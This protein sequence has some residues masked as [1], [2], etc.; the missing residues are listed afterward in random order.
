MSFFETVFKIIEKK[1][2]SNVKEEKLSDSEYLKKNNELPF[3]WI[4]RNREFTNKINCEF[5]HFLNMWL[6]ARKKSPKELYSALKSFVLYLEDAEKLCKSK[7]ECFEFWFNRILISPG[8][9][10]QRKA[11]LQHLTTNFDKLQHN[12]E[13]RASLLTTFDDEIIKKLQANDGILQADF[14]KMFDECVQSDVSS[15][16]YFMAKSGELERTKSG[17]SYILHY[18]TK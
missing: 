3:G 16:L 14:I 1:T 18:K 4:Y 2:A 15:K 12:Y 10:E 5:T 11:E 7:G 9:L 6:E 8:Y 17:R 13:K